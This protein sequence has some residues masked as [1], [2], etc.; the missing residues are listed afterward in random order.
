VDVV[1]EMSGHPAAIAQGFR[2]IRKNGRFSLLGIP[3]QPI[4]TDLAKDIIF[5]GVTVQGIN[6][7]RMFETW[8]Q[9]DALLV[10]GK[11]DLKP[12]ITHHFKMEDFKAAFEVGL[13]GNA[14]KIILE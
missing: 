11:V 7:R 9:M 8:Y 14:G 2:S 10:S 4:T 6:G 13:S 5:P 1:L 3:A 12:L